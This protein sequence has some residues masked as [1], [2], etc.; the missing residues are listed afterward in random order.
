LTSELREDEER[1]AALLAR[2]P[3]G[4]FGEPVDLKGAIVFL[5][6]DAASY[7]HGATLPVDGG[8]LGR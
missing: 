7:V 1:N 5:A 6:S 8:W 4:R 3:A 2:L